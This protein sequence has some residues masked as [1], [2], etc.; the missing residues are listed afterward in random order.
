MFDWIVVMG[1]FQDYIGMTIS[2]SVVICVVLVARAFLKKSPKIFSYVLWFMVIFWILC[3]VTVQGIYGLLPTEVGTTAASIQQTLTEQ[4]VRWIS[5]DMAATEE[6]TAATSGLNGEETPTAVSEPAKEHTY[7]LSANVK[8]SGINVKRV[9]V[10]VFSIVYPLGVIVLILYTIIHLSICRFRLRD[11]ISLG[12]NVYRTDKVGNSLVCGLFR[13]HI[14]VNPWLLEQNLD[15]VLAHERCHI[16]RRDYLIKPFAFMVFSLAWM[17]PLVWVAYICMMRDMEMSCD[18]R[19]MREMSA[20]DRKAYS[21]LLLQACTWTAGR[22]GFSQTPS[23]G[24][25]AMK[26]R[27]KNILEYKKTAGLTLAVSI[28][29]MVI[30]GCSIFS[31]PEQNE[32]A[33]VSSPGVVQME[34]KR[35]SEKV[36]KLT[37]GRDMFGATGQNYGFHENNCMQDKEGN[38][39]MMADNLKAKDDVLLEDELIV[40]Q[41]DG[42][43][44]RKI[45]QP[46]MKEVVDF[47]NGKNAYFAN[48]FH[49]MGQDGKLYLSCLTYDRRLKAVDED[50]TGL[51]QNNWYLLQVDMKTGNWQEMPVPEWEPISNGSGA[52]QVS[53]FADGN[54][55]IRDYSSERVV[56][57]GIY[58]GLDG[59]LIREVK[60][61]NMWQSVQTGDGFYYFFT[62]PENG[63]DSSQIKLALYSEMTGEL[64]NEISIGNGWNNEDGKLMVRYINGEF[65]L[66]ARKGLL[67][68]EENAEEFRFLI[69]AESQSFYYM[70]DE[71]HSPVGLYVQPE[72]EIYYVI[73]TDEALSY[74][75]KKVICR[76]E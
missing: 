9:M 69:Q 44:T 47:A 55:L 39:Y 17:N 76:Y 3:P 2:L 62:Y 43:K 14:Y 50:Y 70:G 22:R 12:G 41:F 26:T 73:F 59:T 13:P 10:Y 63:A 30:C 16:R 56:K 4:P 24:G 49:F 38:M 57:A 21:Y 33:T 29:A 51:M 60:H 11:A 61:S 67:V 37:F 15:Y 25:R 28:F 31:T 52:R 46:W 54:M 18:E 8:E 6:E 40:L 5:N 23:L 32:K 74:D 75:G 58:S 71:S 1:L 64:L 20:Q 45:K 53:V 66:S 35:F 19:A 48:G 68:A 42:E 65:Y 34:G 27:I 36:L 7:E 72:K